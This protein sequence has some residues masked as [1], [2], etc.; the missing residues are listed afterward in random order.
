MIKDALIVIKGT[1]GLGDCTDTIEFT[2]D[3][4]FGVKDGGFYISYDESQ[5]LD[6]DGEVKTKIYIN[7]DNSVLLQRTGAIK[8]RILIENGKRNNCFYSTPLGDINL[9]IYGESVEHDLTADGGYLKL[10]YSVDTNFL[11]ISKNEVNIS[12]KEIN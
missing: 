6:T 9:G 8:N 1:Q 5:M 10:K 7:S 11:L 12:V 4:R 3:G 2:T